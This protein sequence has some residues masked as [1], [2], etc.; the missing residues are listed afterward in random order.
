MQKKEENK[1]FNKINNN[2]KKIPLKNIAYTVG[3][4]FE[5]QGHFKNIF[6]ND[7]V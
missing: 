3:N 5:I 6:M 1:V 7:I 2:N 4:Y